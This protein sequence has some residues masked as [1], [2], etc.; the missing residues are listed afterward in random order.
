MKTIA[1]LIVS[2]LLGLGILTAP[3]HAEEAAAAPSCE[4]TVQEWRTRALTAE[5]QVV[6][7]EGYKTLASGLD[8]LLTREKSNVEQGNRVITR[9]V[10]REKMH[11]AKIAELRKIVRELRN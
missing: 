9:L 11:K 2:V 4:D 8:A 10:K 3:A 6:E 7:L 1:T 5:A